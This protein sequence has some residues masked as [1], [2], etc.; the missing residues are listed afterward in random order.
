M[1]WFKGYNWR[2]IKNFKIYNEA[3]CN[4]LKDIIEELK[5]DLKNNW[6]IMKYFI[7]K[8]IVKYI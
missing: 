8:C 2:I 1:K 3:L 6:N 7:N 5:N 4:V